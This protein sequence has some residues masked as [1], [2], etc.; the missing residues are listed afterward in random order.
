MFNSAKNFFPSM[1]DKKVDVIGA[2]V[3]HKELLEVLCQ[4]GARVTLCDRRTA[5]Q[6]G[7]LYTK[8]KEMGVAFQLGEGY[9]SGLSGEVIFRTPGLNFYTKELT[10]ARERGQVVTSEIE[11]LMELCP[12]PIYG[13]SGSDGKTTTTTIVSELL[14]AS[15][16]KVHLGGNIGTPL[17]T[18]LPQ[19]QE[20][21]A[22]VLELS[23]FQL[24][25]L[26]RSPDVAVLTNI[27]P[28]H[29]DVHKDMEEYIQSKAQIIAHQGAF[30]R[31]VLSF[32]NHITR[33]FQS[34]TRGI[35]YGFSIKE[36]PENGAFLREDGMLCFSENGVVTEIVHRDGIKLPGLHNVENYLAA[37]SA[38]WGEVS[39][40]I[41]AD[42]AK[43]FGGVEHRI[44]YVGEKNGVRYYN[45]AIATSPTR[46]IAG[47]RS[48]QEKML[49]IMGGYDKK[50]PFEPMVE[51]VIKSV[52]V[53]ILFGD[54]ADKIRSA[55]TA[56]PNFD[57]TKLEILEAFS[58]EEAVRLAYTNAK[59][60]EVVSLSPACAS[61]DH[62]PNF[63][64]K[65]VHYKQLVH[66]IVLGD[67]A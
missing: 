41:I 62:Y 57:P 1:K 13:V 12:C 36:Q 25:S 32:D 54:T 66:S 22:V 55:V 64:A 44:E 39:I 28:N 48:F 33:S 23:S 29:L 34:R 31:A 16:R 58:L 47:L 35:T 65:G 8:L 61:F 67:Q 50:I 60:G 5:E 30:G 45:D 9:L 46:V 10:E 2:G 53:L 43:N 40:E 14:K 21:D 56:S 42:V 37:I 63:G 51:D 18:R 49:I 59:S 38:V 27:T 15:G 20:S 6:L 4:N 11:V 24:M 26:R 3:S 17:V 19:M 7:D 52:R